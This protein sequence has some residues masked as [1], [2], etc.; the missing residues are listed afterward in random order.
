MRFAVSVLGVLFLSSAVVAQ[1]QRGTIVGT[2]SDASGAVVPNATVQVVN[3]ETDA[4]FKGASNSTG[5]YSI[6]YLPYGKYSLSANAS[7]FK[8]FNV[9]AIEVAAATTTTINISL[10]VGSAT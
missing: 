8:T 3:D 2:V 5:Y 9:Q 10:T 6:P 1:T 7:G 4:K